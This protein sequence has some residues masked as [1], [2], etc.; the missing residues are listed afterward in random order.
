M[1]KP[2]RSVLFFAQ[3]L[4]YLADTLENL[5]FRFPRTLTLPCF[6]EIL[7][8]NLGFPLNFSQIFTLNTFSTKKLRSALIYPTYKRLNSTLFCDFIS[9]MNNH[10]NYAQ[11]Y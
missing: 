7:K 3:K 4:L 1:P 2:G 5:V 11:V 6:G 10:Y 9:L 8:L